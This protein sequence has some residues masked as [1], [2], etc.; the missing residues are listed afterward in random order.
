MNWILVAMM[1]CQLLTGGFLV[2]MVWDNHRVNLERAKH[3]E[4]LQRQLS[5]SVPIL[6]VDPEADEIIDAMMER[7]GINKVEYIDE[8][9]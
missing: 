6:P 9:E 8:E 7:L 3:L 5:R 1:L 2:W 4:E